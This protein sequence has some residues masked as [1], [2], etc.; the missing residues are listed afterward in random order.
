MLDLKYIPT[1]RTGYSPNPLIYEVVDLNNTV[2]FILPDN[3]KVIVTIDDLRIKSNLKIIQ[4]II[5]LR[6]L[7]LNNFGFYS[8]TFLSSR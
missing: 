4:T 5:S 6:S 7:F 8:I 1:N 2:K 3:V